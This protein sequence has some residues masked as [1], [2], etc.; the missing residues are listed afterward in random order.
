MSIYSFTSLLWTKLNTVNWAIWFLHE[1]GISHYLNWNWNCVTW[2]RTEIVI[3]IGIY[4]CSLQI[5]LVYLQNW[6]K[7]KS[8]GII[9]RTKYCLPVRWEFRCTTDRCHCWYSQVP[10]WTKCWR[11]W[12]TACNRSPTDYSS[13]TSLPEYN[14]SPGFL[15]RAYLR[16]LKDGGLKGR[17][18]RPKVED[19]TGAAR[20]RA[21]SSAA[22]QI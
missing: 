14:V 3:K 7:I 19:R 13:H 21:F 11:C 4:F 16:L 15:K 18:S 20:C 6:I 22:A 17:K 5:N 10:V 8:R 12:M 1:I 9:L 2:R